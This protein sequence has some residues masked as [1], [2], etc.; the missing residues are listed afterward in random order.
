MPDGF[1]TRLG[2]NAIVECNSRLRPSLTEIVSGSP[3]D[4]DDPNDPVGLDLYRTTEEDGVS[5][6]WLFKGAG[7]KRVQL[8]SRELNSS[9]L[10]QSERVVALPS[11]CTPPFQRVGLE[12]LDSIE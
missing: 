5:C 3:K 4:C 10:V 7:E 11:R 1:F 8:P 9:S 2:K 12:P 6:F